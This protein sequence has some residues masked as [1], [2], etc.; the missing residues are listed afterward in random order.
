MLTFSEFNLNTTI[1]IAAII[2]LLIAVYII[3]RE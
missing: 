2:I 3:T 1:A